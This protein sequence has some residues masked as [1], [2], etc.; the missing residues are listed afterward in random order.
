M[1][2]EADNPLKKWEVLTSTG[3]DRGVNL[4]D[5]L[6]KPGGGIT[7]A[8]VQ[9]LDNDRIPAVWEAISGTSDTNSDTDSDGL[10]DGFEFFGKGSDSTSPTGEAIWRVD[11][12]GKGSYTVM[13]SPASA[14]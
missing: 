6:L 3:I 5:R 4:S 13:S 11:V 9:D 10:D 8:F 2:E 14:T 7:F 12:V 1:A